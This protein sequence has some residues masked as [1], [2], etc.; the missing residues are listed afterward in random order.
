[1]RCPSSLNL[2]QAGVILFWFWQYVVCRRIGK[3]TLSYMVLQNR[4]GFYTNSVFPDAS[5]KNG[6][7]GR[8]SPG[9]K[10]LIRGLTAALIHSQDL[11]YYPM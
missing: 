6:R 4:H 2:A 10:G 11:R 9:A 3:P 8:V 5:G 1:M 7:T